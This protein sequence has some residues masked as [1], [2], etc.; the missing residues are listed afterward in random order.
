[1]GGSDPGKSDRDKISKRKKTA[2]HKA[3]EL[4]DLCHAKVFLLIEH[5]RGTTIFNSVEDHSWPPP[6]LVPGHDEQAEDVLHR[7]YPSDIRREKV[8]REAKEWC[9]Y[10]MYRASLRKSLTVPL[11]CKDNA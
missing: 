10:F 4:A 1:M 8:K 6:S 11:P 9:Y 5:P 7:V 2:I 3:F